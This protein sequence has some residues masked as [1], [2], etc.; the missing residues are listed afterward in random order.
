VTPHTPPEPS[1]S[2]PS[3]NSDAR[4]VAL[5]RKIESGSM[6]PKTVSVPD[7]R[8]LIAFLMGDGYS[9]AEMAQILQVAPRP[10]KGRWRCRARA[11]ADPGGTD[12]PTRMCV[13]CRYHIPRAHA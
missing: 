12:K 5:L 8:Q 10:E 13:R 6:S 7:R 4:T 1:G 2:N 3:G 11:N 9:T